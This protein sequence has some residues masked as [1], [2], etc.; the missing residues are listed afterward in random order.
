VD[1]PAITSVAL[2]EVRKV[3]GRQPA[4]AGVSFALAPGQVTLLMGPN[5]AGKSTLLAI[6][7]TL[8]RPTSGTV[9]YGALDHRAAESALRGRIGL[10]AHTPLLYDR[11]SCRENLQFFA[12]LYG[13]DR[14]TELVQRW[15]ARVGM[16]E[17][18]DKEVGQLSR[19]MLQRVALARALLPDPD[20]LLL[21]EPFT[22]L[23]RD[24][25]RLLREELRGAR[26]AGK[27]IV[28]VTHDVE[29]V[30]GLCDRLLVLKRGR[31]AAELAE[32]GLPYRQIQEHYHAAV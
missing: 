26:E 25:V 12:R 17:A 19:G 16:E 11:M 29:A 9:R 10:L 13:L 21:D 23:D 1:S 30:D 20:L 2:E 31:L 5:G 22:G 32:A 24:A 14:P 18:A 6:L 27:I 8:S 15:L 3:F 7:S 28:V 4:L